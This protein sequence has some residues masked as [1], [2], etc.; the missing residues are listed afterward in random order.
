MT[1]TQVRLAGRVV[2]VRLIHTDDVSALVA[3]YEGLSADDTYHRFFSA[4]PLIRPLVEQWV[5]TKPSEGR[6]LVAVDDNGAII[7]DAGL[8]SITSGEWSGD[9]E[10]D[11]TVSAA[12]RGWFGSFLLDRLIQEGKSLDVRNLQAR[13][14]RDNHAMLA[15]AARRGYIVLDR[16]EPTELRIA[17]GVRETMPVWPSGHDRVRV[18]VESRASGWDAAASARSFGM[19]PVM[20]PG[21]K[22]GPRP[23]CP[24]AEGRPCSLAAHA[25]VVVHALSESDERARAVL[26]RHASLHPRALVMVE[27]GLREHRPLPDTAVRLDREDPQAAETILRALGR[28]P[29][30]PRR[31]RPE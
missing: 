29:R 15:V 8:T 1:V 16:D 12:A 28:E 13:I 19:T 2:T 7:A 9:A 10:L 20:C 4:A 31:R 17:M 27:Q 3:M 14:L 25:D 30:L 11:M 22:G 21:P 24:A 6:R 5:N 18:V 26:T 23:R